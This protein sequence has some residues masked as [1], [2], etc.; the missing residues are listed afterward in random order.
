M[1]TGNSVMPFRWRLRARCGIPAANSSLTDAPHSMIAPIRLLAAALLFW[2]AFLPSRSDCAPVRIAYAAIAANTAGVWMAQGTGAFKNQGLEVQF[3]YISSSA[4]NVQ[5]LLSGSIDVMVGGASGIVSAAAR[6]AP[7]VAVGS[8]MNKAPATLYV[9]PEI[10]D[11]AQL[12][13]ALLGISRPNSSTHVLTA[14]VLRK[15][16]LENAATLRSFGDIPGIHAAF[17]RKIIAGMVSTVTPKT[18]NRA[19]ANAADLDIPYAMSVIAVTR[20]YLQTRRATVERVLRAYVEGVATMVRNKETASRI[21]AKY[22]R[23]DE[24]AFLDETYAFVRKYTERTPRVDARVVPL[25]LEFDPVKGVEAEALTARMIDNS[26][27]DQLPQEQF[28]QKQ[29]GKEFR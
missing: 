12:K 20:N 10:A 21:L 5:A 27:V 6:G 14:L 11:P 24:P 26:I 8:Q 29:F 23:R 13:G 2:P 18:P 17:D 9:Q 16:G 1:Q 15:L 3:I 7:L 25:L 19:L 28:I 4:T 22:L